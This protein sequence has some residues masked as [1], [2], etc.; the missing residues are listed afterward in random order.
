MSGALRRMN[1]LN[2]SYLALQYSLLLP[3]GEDGY[4]ED[5]PFTSRKNISENNQKNSV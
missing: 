3:Y 5:I 1:E 4:T 2:V